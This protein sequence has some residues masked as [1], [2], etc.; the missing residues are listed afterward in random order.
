MESELINANAR[1]ATWHARMQRCGF[2]FLTTQFVCSLIG[3]P[4]HYTGR[5]IDISHKHLGISPEE[6]EEFM[7]L[8]MNVCMD[9]G[10]DVQTSRELRD[11]FLSIADEV[12]SK[13]GET[14]PPNPGPQVHTGSSLYARLGGVYPISLFTDRLVDALLVD[15]RI[16]LSVDEDRRSPSALKYLFTEVFCNLAGGGE[17]MTAP[18]L[19][20]TKL[21][22]PKSAWGIVT[23]T[24]ELAADH[25]SKEDI[26]DVLKALE[27]G[28]HLIIDATSA[29]T[30]VCLSGAAAVKDL[31]A[32]AAGQKLSAAQLAARLAA[33]GQHVA[34]RRRVF[35][36]PR[37][38]YGRV[39]GIFGLARFASIMMD[40]WMQNDVLNA[41]LAVA[42]WHETNQV[43]G[44]KFFVTQ[45]LAYLTG[46]PQ[47][48]TGRA[49][50][51]SHKHLN[52][53]VSQWAHFM[54]EADRILDALVKDPVLQRSLRGILASFR[55]QC[56][57]RPGEQ[58]WPDPGPSRPGDDTVG[59]TYHSLGGVYPIARYADML[60]EAVLKGD[61]V[62][63]EWHPLEDPQ[64]TRHPP[65]LKY[66]VTELLCRCTGGPEVVTSRSFDPAKLGVQAHQWPA[67]MQLAAEAATRSFRSM[68]SGGR[69]CR[70]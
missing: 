33:P 51:I 13:P 49:M 6:W 30:G 26:P 3:G 57:V 25:F 68:R 5:P 35:G 54:Q 41:N 50:E 22:V 11:L 42:R 4:Q 24:A 40:A 15:D 55:D 53:T 10:I 20:F 37:T 56:I 59:T 2:K 64:S 70:P 39:G 36:D 61:R 32:A 58:P 38:L 21:L 28:K 9:Q 23:D 12:I 27:A 19:E 34:A 1:V 66:M 62:Q 48:Y 45:I 43:Y 46:G 44:F 8:F 31:Q 52:I 18:D 29:D 47:R 17:M 7:R 16:G 67:F 14:V 65:G 63:V 60:V 69:C